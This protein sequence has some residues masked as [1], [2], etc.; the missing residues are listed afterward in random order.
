MGMIQLSI[1]EAVAEKYRSRVNFHQY[2]LDPTTDAHLVRLFNINQ[3][4]ALLVL[5]QGELVERKIGPVRADE[6]EA[7]LS[8]LI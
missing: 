4:P 6:L 2:V 8:G 7:M 5:N 1:L 3:L